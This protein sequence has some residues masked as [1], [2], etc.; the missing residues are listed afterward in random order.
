MGLDSPGQ[1]KTGDNVLNTILDIYFQISSLSAFPS[2][3]LYNSA[4][5][6][7]GEVD[8]CPSALICRV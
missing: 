5:R 1:G 2:K 3:L 6:R 4:G 7:Y 8:G